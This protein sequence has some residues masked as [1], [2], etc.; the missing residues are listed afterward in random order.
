MNKEEAEKIVVAAER[1][2]AVLR[3]KNKALRASLE[4]KRKENAR[5]REENQRLKAQLKAHLETKMAPVLRPL[6]LSD[7]EEAQDQRRVVVCEK[8]GWFLCASAAEVFEWMYDN[9]VAGVECGEDY[10][11]QEE[12]G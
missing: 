3:E 8:C 5:L 7:S 11:K 12:K 6:P 4:D 2:I 1:I 10:R 9:K